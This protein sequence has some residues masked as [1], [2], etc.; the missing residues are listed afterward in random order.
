MTA[1][2]CLYVPHGD[3]RRVDMCIE[4][5]ESSPPRNCFLFE[6][7][8][9]LVG[10]MLL[11]FF[12]FLCCV[13]LLCLLV[14]VMCHLYP[15]VPISLSCTF[16]IAPSNKITS[17]KSYTF[18]FAHVSTNLPLDM[19]ELFRGCGNISYSCYQSNHEWLKTYS[20]FQ[21]L[22]SIFCLQLF[23]FQY[24]HINQIRHV[25]HYEAWLVVNIPLICFFLFYDLQHMCTCIYNVCCLRTIYAKYSNSTTK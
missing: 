14:F 17:I 19:A 24:N 7:T 9:L 2:S 20:K 1:S 11:I 6:S 13:V 22:I 8:W 23:V 15:M 25:Q 3:M 16:L 12:N 18:N 5:C 4:L 21:V 10:P